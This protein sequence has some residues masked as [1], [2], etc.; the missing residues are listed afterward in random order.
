MYCA[1]IGTPTSGPIP[2]MSKPQPWFASDSLRLKDS[3]AQDAAIDDVTKK[4]KGKEAMDL[5][6]LLTFEP[7]AD[8]HE[9]E[10]VHLIF[11]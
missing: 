2:E 5:V 3:K 9:F 4:F 11:L 1:L 10:F 6:T 7:N 8:M